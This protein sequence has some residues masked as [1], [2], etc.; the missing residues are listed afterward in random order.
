[1]KPTQYNATFYQRAPWPV[2][3]ASW[4]RRTWRR[5]PPAVRAVVVALLAAPLLYLALVAVLV[6]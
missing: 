6:F 2:R 5:L 1:M 4:F 3:S